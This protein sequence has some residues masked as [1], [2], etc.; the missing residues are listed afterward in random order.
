[1]R[2]SAIRWY[3]PVALGLALAC[4]VVAALVV[5][6]EW[7]EAVRLGV[8]GQDF[9]QYLEATRRWITSGSPYLETEIAGPFTP[10]PHTFLHPPT[11]LLLLTPF[12]I[13]PAWLWWALPA[14]AIAWTVW[15]WR[16]APWTWP[17]MAALLI[18]PRGHI[19]VIF[20]NSDL[21]VWAIL[22]V[23]LRFGWAAPL[24]VIKPSL[25]PLMLVGV[26]RRDWWWMAGLVALSSMVFGALWLEWA[27]VIRHAPM[28]WT[29]S[30]ASLTFLSLPLIAW[31]GRTRP[32]RPLPTIHLPIGLVPR[33]AAVRSRT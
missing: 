4:I 27:A 6:A 25:W 26:G 16:P 23:G 18:L 33:P 12:L 20:G 21:W 30:V 28:D 9:A 8:V 2:P 13:L 11:T 32:V 5:Q 29:Y 7:R 17:L 15:S 22:A 14:V 10:G 19:A 1:M 3:R 24:I 31:A